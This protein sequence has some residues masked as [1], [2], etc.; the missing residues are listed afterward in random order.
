MG[1]SRF[2]KTHIFLCTRPTSSTGLPIFL[3]NHSNNKVGR[4]TT[5]SPCPPLTVHAVARGL[6]INA[7]YSSDVSIVGTPSEMR[8]TGS[9][10]VGCPCT[11]L[12]VPAS[13][14]A[15]TATQ[16]IKSVSLASSVIADPLAQLMT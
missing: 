2:T 14:R 15:S 10:Y 6:I 1:S 16:M 3:S 7:D 12:S 5:I 11:V 9:I 13:C 4:F 8:L